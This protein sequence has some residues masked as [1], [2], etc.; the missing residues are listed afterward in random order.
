MNDYLAKRE[1][2]KV[3]YHHWDNAAR[4]LCEAFD[5]SFADLEQAILQAR[6]NRTHLEAIAEYARL[7]NALDMASDEWDRAQEQ[8]LRRDLSLIDC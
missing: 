6:T 4:R 7:S 2:Y 1:R 5:C 8:I 3:C